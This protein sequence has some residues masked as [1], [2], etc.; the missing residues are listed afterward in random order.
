MA[1]GNGLKGKLGEFQF[2]LSQILNVSALI[3]A[4]NEAEDY[5]LNKEIDELGYYFSAFMNSVQ[6]IKDAAETSMNVKFSWSELSFSYGGFIRY[7]RNAITHDG[8]S[9][10]NA[11]Q[12]GH[13]YIIGPLRR[14]SN[15]GKVIEFDPPKDDVVTIVINFS[16]EFLL[17]LERLVCE[18][19]KEI[20][21]PNKDDLAQMLED[22]QNSDFI[23]DFAKELMVQ[24]KDEVISSFDS[25]IIDKYK[26]INEKI[27]SVREFVNLHSKYA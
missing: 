1:V 6:S 22:S 19:G 14:I 17:N 18:H 9:I 20:P 25:H 13:H 8:S 12:G 23:S 5:P 27:I 24:N 11:F 3:R 2:F 15:K 4:K 26:E 7:C 21:S 16:S 10:I